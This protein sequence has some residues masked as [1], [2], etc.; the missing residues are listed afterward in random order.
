MA[1]QHQEQAAA[2]IGAMGQ[3]ETL[4]DGAVVSLFDAP[5]FYASGVQ[6]APVANEVILT[7][8]VARPGTATGPDGKTGNIARIV[9][10]ANVTL[11]LM[12]FKEAVLAMQA[13]LTEYEKEHGEIVT[14]FLRAQKA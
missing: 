2:A 3:P 7:F 5:S 13:I 12:T 14:P 8:N 11:G 10:I 6:V 9:P 1:D 4:A